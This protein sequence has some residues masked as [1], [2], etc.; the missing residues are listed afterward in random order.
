MLPRRASR[1]CLHAARH[2]AALGRGRPRRLGAPLQRGHRGGPEG[3]DLLGRGRRAGGC[4]QDPR[5]TKWLTD[6][7][8]QD[9]SI[10]K[11]QRKA[12]EE[13]VLARGGKK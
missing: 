8:T 2:P 13:R 3:L 11:E 6:R 9:A 12:A 10:L 5:L 7:M 4:I 1:E